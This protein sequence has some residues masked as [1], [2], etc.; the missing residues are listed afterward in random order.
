[1]F[2]GFD[3]FVWELS[4]IGYQLYEGVASY[5]LLLRLCLLMYGRVAGPRGFKRWLCRP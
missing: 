4:A 3:S 2:G 1:M 5:P